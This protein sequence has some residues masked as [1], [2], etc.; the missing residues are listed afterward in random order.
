MASVS[1]DEV[2]LV[3]HRGVE[4]VGVA[5]DRQRDAVADVQAGVAS[6]LLHGADQVVG[7]ALARQLGGHLGVEGDEAA[8]RQL[9][10]RAAS[11]LPSA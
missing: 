11:P 5:G 10:V 7:Q 3:S 4:D 1:A 6:G 9:A 8:T 2:R